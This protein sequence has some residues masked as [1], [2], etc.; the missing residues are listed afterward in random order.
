MKFPGVV[1]I[2]R[3]RHPGV[4]GHH[5]IVYGQDSLAVGPQPGHL[6]TIQV[7]DHAGEVSLSAG[8]HGDVVDGINELRDRGLHCNSHV[9]RDPRSLDQNYNL[10]SLQYNEC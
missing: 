5:V 2:V 8:R 10:T 4:V 7:V 3:D 1:T 9:S 6:V